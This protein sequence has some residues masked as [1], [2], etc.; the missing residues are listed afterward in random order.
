[1]VKRLLSTI[2]LK[3]GKA[4]LYESG[5]SG[6]VVI[7][8]LIQCG[9]ALCEGG[10]EFPYKRSAFKRGALKK[11]AVP[12]GWRISGAPHLRQLNLFS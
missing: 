5:V 12:G 6:W 11:A 8:P 3:G 7:R 1:M 10:L 9:S 2:Q 4:H